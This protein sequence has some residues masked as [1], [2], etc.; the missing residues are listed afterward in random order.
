M[1]EINNGTKQQ[2]YGCYFLP[3]L[4]VDKITKARSIDHSKL[5]SHAIFFDI[6]CN[7]LDLNGLR[8]L[9]RWLNILLWRIELTVEEGVDQCR[10]TKTR[11]TYRYPSSDD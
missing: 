11:F 7:R 4:I 2:S 1:N 10:F 5:Q 9:V 6:R 3:L 8:S